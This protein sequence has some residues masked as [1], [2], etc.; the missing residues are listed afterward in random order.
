M[1][2]KQLIYGI[3]D[4][5]P[6]PILILAGAQHV[7]TLFGATTLVP[8]IC[9]P[10]MGMTTE[11]IGA[12]IG[13]V[14]F[15]MGIATLIQTHPKLGSGLPIVQGSSFSFIPPIMTIIGA[16]KAM[17]PDVVMQYIGGSLVV[18]GLVLSMLGY[19]KLIGRI[20]K[21]ITPVVIGPTIMAIGFTLAPTAIQFNA[22]NYWPISLLV[23]AMVFF[24]S[25]VSKNKY[26]KIFAVLGSITI[27]Y[28]ICLLLS[29]MG[30]FAEGH[31]AFINLQGVIDA[32]WIR[33]NLVMPWGM[34]KVS[35]LALGAIAAGFFCVMIESIGDYHN[36][37]F[38]A[39]IDD[40]TPG[41][42]NR[43]IGAEGICCAISGCLGSV[44]TTS[45]T[46]NI[47]LIGL[48][49]VASR[50]V[51][52]AGAVILIILSLIGKLGALI[53]T[54]PS[55]VIGGA[56]I[57]LFGTIGAL[58]IQNLMRADM[59]SQRNIL[60]VGFAFLMALGLPGWVETNQAIFTN[61]FGSTFGGMLWA[62]MKTPMAVA[63]ILS[64]V[65]DS[66][67]PGTDAERGIRP[68]R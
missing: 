58:G 20:R 22:A 26:C 24:F 33:Y 23:V 39:G 64:A 17:G 59:G 14:Y 47:G 66:L 37:S 52:R 65:C 16:Y 25:L 34:P 3:D 41:Q 67:I 10:A 12:F 54:M 27:A 62:V 61:T 56:Y 21:I 38:A 55:P 4:R 7:L 46:E 51:V 15:S 53:A 45:Y 40:P 9:G 6:T 48:T 18:G 28:L 8:L 2:K 68:A 31:A 30:I 29:V 36:C 43:G 63:G 5:P 35:G 50:H 1:A 60:I 32:P 57:T 49:G 13:C 19:S 42:I 11:Q 44:G